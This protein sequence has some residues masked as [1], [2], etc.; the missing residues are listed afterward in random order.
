M[1]EGNRLT[2]QNGKAKNGGNGKSANNRNSEPLE[3]E[4][5]APNRCSFTGQ[6]EADCKVLFSVGTVFVGPEGIRILNS[7]LA[8]FECRQRGG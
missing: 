6:T 2:E 3:L 8:D 4:H 7:Q 5:G 1:T